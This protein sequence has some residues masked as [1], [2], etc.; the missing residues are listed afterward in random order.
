MC[1]CVSIRRIEYS[2]SSH[3]SGKRI[4]ILSHHRY[5]H[6]RRPPWPPP[7]TIRRTVA[8][9]NIAVAT[10]VAVVDVKILNH[11]TITSI[12]SSIELRKFARRS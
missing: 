5:R 8:T 7:I 4:L 1:V 12:T 6:R 11:T 3:V 10:G 2:S 9:R